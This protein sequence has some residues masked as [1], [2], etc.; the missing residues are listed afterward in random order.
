MHATRRPSRGFTLLELLVVIIVL[1]LLAGLVAPQIFGRVGEAKVT[2]ARTQMSLVGTALDSY[3]LDNG[4]YPTT[5]QGLQALRDKPTREPIATNWRGPYLRKEVPL[6]PWGRA[7][8]YRAPG[9]RN[10]N[11]Y[12]LSTLGRDG[13]EGGTGEDADQIGQ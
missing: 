6:D 10:P 12:D 8:V 5:E 11:G 1:G 3:R 9:S 2:T 13:T 4:A 7:Y